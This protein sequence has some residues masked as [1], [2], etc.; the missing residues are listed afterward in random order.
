[1]FV[2]NQAICWVKHAQIDKA[3]SLQMSNMIFDRV[4]IHK[5]SIIT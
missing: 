3:H 4:T 2:D 5:K 1:M